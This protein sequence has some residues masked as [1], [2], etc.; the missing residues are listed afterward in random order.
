MA[1]KGTEEVTT[2]SL[3]LRPGMPEAA[4]GARRA[5]AVGRPAWS[6]AQVRRVLATEGQKRLTCF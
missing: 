1:R 5:D 3:R 4:A 6:T 2:A